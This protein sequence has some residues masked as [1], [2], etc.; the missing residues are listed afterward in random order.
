MLEPVSDTAASSFKGTLAGVGCGIL[1]LVFAAVALALLFLIGIGGGGDRAGSAAL[2]WV[3]L[4]AAGA[5]S[6]A[7]AGLAGAGAVAARV[8][9]RRA[10][11]AAALIVFVLGGLALIARVGFSSALQIAFYLSPL[12]IAMVAGALIRGRRA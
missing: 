10:G 2:G 3:V 1:A 4:G 5:L 6:A 12:P 7:F 9:G 8:G 11:L